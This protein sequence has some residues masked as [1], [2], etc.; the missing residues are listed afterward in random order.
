MLSDEHFMARCLQL[1]QLGRRV[2]APNPMVG[3]VIVYEDQIIGE[4]YHA[5][6]GGPHAEVN[7]IRSVKDSALLSKATI[8]VSLEPCSHFGKTPPCADLLIQNSFRRVVIGT[9]DPNVQVDG[10]G[11]E[12]LE[13]AGIAVR[14]GVMEKECRALNRHF[15]TYHEKK[16]PYIVLKWAQTP[17]GLIDNDVQPGG[18]AWISQPETQDYV[19]QL[20]ASLHGIL[21]GRKTVLKDNPRLTVRKVE[22]INPVRIVLDSQLRLDKN[23][24]VFSNDGTTIVLNT[25]KT[26]KN[27]SIEY[28]RIDAMDV[29][30][31]CTALYEEGIQSV[32]VE[33]GKATLQSFIDAGLWDEAR[34]I[35]GQHNFTSGTAAPQLHGTRFKTERYF[36]DTIETYL[37]S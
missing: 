17:N 25:V 8:Y 22:G 10:R 4:G 36:G 7:A 21:V 34:R 11:I 35:T 24:S 18:I 16:R 27:G 29:S 14:S 3:A 31:I 30:Q 1:A 13:K 2:V 28:R 9:R 20:R 15:Y 12:R 37:N 33:G 23:A 32:L 5:V 19:H 6:Y 26:E